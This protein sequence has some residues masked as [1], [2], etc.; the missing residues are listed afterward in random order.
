MSCTDVC[1]CVV[2]VVQFERKRVKEKRF[3]DS[4]VDSMRYGG[5][6]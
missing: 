4:L 5:G 6:E 1:V 2:V 3:D